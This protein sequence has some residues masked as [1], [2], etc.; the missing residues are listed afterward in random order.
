M[1]ILM[2]I[3]L[4]LA[5]LVCN[6]IYCGQRIMADLRQ[7]RRTNVTLGS[8]AFCGALMAT[9]VDGLG[10]ARQSRPSLEPANAHVWTALRW[11]A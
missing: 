6:L 8:F 9:G 3:L 11:Q 10:H 5:L 1:G 2:V 4:T 7:S